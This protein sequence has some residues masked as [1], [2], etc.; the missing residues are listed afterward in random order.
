[1]VDYVAEQL[2]IGDASCIKR[3]AERVKRL[4][5]R[6]DGLLVGPE[7]QRVSELERLRRA[8]ARVSDPEMVRALDRTAEVLGIGAGRVPCP[9]WAAGQGAHA[10]GPVVGAAHGDGA[11]H[12]AAL[13]GRRGGRRTGPVQRGDGHVAALC[14]IP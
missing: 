7:G 11:G 3:Y 10:A 2:G 6:L 8:P 12:R 4:P 5:E 13:G 1:M 9:L 14:D